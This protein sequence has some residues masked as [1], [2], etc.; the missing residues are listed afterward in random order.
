MHFK[1]TV[2][3]LNLKYELNQINNG[4]ILNSVNS[5]PRGHP[6]FENL[7]CLLLTTSTP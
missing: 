1:E 5:P 3:V 2:I 7:I 6:L 4:K